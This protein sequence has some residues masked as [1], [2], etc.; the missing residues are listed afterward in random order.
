MPTHRITF[1]QQIFIQEYLVDLDGTNA[2]IRAGY[3]PKAARQYG[4][5][6]IRR[7]DIAAAIQKEMDDRAARLGITPE[8]IIEEYAKIAFA[9][10]RR[11]V[12]WDDDGVGIK[13]AGA[14]SDEAAA[15]LAS[16]ASLPPA[17]GKSGKRG[18]RFVVTTFDKKRALDSLALLLGVALPRRDTDRLH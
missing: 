15:A 17:T 5:Y 10:M 11:L 12:D 8:R 14:I 7:P 3:S 6:L 2:A 18:A 13:D 16:I 4:A 9:D 1:R